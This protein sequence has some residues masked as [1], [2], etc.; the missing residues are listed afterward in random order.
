MS[1]Y[2]KRKSFDDELVSKAMKN[3]DFRKALMADPKGTLEKEWG[4]SLPADLNIT[5]HQETK[6]HLH[7]VLPT[8]AAASDEV[9]SA[10]M[11]PESLSSWGHFGECFAECTQCGNNQTTCAPGPT[12]EE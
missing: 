10:E 8:A 2:E 7:V 11:H 1:L 4:V 5:V 6:N 12:G 9:Q 3:D